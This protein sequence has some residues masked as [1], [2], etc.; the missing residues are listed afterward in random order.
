MTY[1]QDFIWKKE[2]QVT[3]LLK[4]YRDLGFQSVELVKATD[5]LVKMKKASAKIF[6]TFTSN[7]V[8]SGLRGFFAQ[9]INLGMADVLVTT[10]GAI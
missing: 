3:D 1:V 2:M 7:M 9:I 10:A 4:G 6:L 5:T 8:T